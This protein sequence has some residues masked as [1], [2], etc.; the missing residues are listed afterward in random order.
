MRR[1]LIALK[2]T[3]GSFSRNIIFENNTSATQQRFLSFVNP[4]LQSVQERSGLYAY[5]VQIV[6]DDPSLIDRNILAVNIFIQPA[7]AIEIIRLSF[8]ITPTSTT[9]T[10]G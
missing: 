2:T 5:K 3:I 6:T 8:I 10:G 7:R 1:L 9:V 4:Y